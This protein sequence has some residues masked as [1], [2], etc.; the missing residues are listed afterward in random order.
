MLDFVKSVCMQIYS[1]KF[2]MIV[3]DNKFR[4]NSVKMVSAK[5]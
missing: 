2:E 4:E 3:V 5:L 1:I